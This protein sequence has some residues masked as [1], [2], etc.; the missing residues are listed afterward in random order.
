MYISYSDI[1][2]IIDA[3]DKLIKD[4]QILLVADATKTIDGSRR[5][6]SSR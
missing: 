4:L 1:S 3:I 6:E 5:E 2:V